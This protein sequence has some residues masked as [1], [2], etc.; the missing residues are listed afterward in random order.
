MARDSGAFEARS[1]LV[2][3][4]FGVKDMSRQLTGR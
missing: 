1:G 2:R 3:F 4:H